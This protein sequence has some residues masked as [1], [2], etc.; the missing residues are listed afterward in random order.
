MQTLK[1]CEVVG[2]EVS[3]EAVEDVAER[4]MPTRALNRRSVSAL[5]GEKTK[6]FKRKF[7]KGSS[8]GSFCVADVFAKPTRFDIPSES[9]AGGTS[10]CAS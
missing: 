1:Q 2:S 4:A 6:S 10:M 9:A 8:H 3:S 7:A 5:E